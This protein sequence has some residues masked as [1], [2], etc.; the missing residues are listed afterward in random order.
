MPSGNI[1]DKATNTASYAL[2]LLLA[3]CGTMLPVPRE[4]KIPVP[5]PCVDARDVP[6]KPP[7]ATD[8][9][10]LKLDDYQFT[11]TIW[12]DRRM[13]Q[14]YSDLQAALLIGCVK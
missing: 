7:I 14:Q 3:G 10:L 6:A 4:V 11:L 8:A 2:V 5:V 9:D 1:R 12:L 13:L